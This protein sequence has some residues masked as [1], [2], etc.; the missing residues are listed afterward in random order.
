MNTEKIFV[1]DD[2]ANIR[3]TI[4]EALEEERFSVQ[5]YASP[6]DALKEIRTER[7]A[8]VITDL[9]MP[10]MDGLEVVQK[11]KAINPEINLVLITAYASLDTAIGAIRA[12]A[13]DYLVKPFKIEELLKTVQKA[14]SQKRLPAKT[15]DG[16]HFQE[17]YEI[18]NLIGASGEMK[19]I[20]K[21]IEKV[22]KTESTVLIIGESGSGKE[23]VARAIHFESK[24]RKGPFVSI[25]C[26]ALPET[27]LE[28]ELFGYEKGAFTGAA[29]SKAGLF[30]LAEHGTFLLDEV[31]E[32]S[33]NLQVK[34]LR[35]LQERV[36]KRLGGV[37]DLPVHF[38]LI[39]AT[40][41]NLPEE[42]KAG[43]FREDLFYRLNVIPLLL[44][45]LRERREDI[46]LF[47]SHFLH[48]YCEKYGIQKQFK[49]T[50]DAMAVFQNYD[51][52]GNV[53][54]LENV[55]DRLVSLADTGEIDG[56]IAE[57][58][59]QSGQFSS[60]PSQPIN[61]A[62]NLK[63]NLE[64]YERELIQKAIAESHGNKNQAAKKLNLTRQ[65]L[66]YKLQKYGMN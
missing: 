25:N 18:K 7:P 17:R 39:A 62:S 50:E 27:L 19:E 14:L 16:G 5:C 45:S 8:L 40:S 52:P 10:E 55:M 41:K 21:L 57:K 63:D 66:H 64:G 48:F 34:L 12:G 15:G 36:L 47:V 37:K 38:R 31:G 6:L 11:V 46:P 9:V 2:E 60:A 33:V 61:R 4:K 49:I 29:A 13:N 20:F 44:P 42:I 23:M 30:E 56:P 53:R 59:I 65:A 54:E 35:V 58:A 43:R 3:Q 32:M 26:A 22:A 24:Q 28:S 1:I 51:W